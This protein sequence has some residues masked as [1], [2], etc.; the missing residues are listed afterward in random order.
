MNILDEN[1]PEGLGKRP[2]SF[3]IPMGLARGLAV[4]GGL[5]GSIIGKQVPF[6]LNILEKLTGTYTFSS[7]KIQRELGFKPRYNLYNTISDTMRLSFL[8]SSV[9]SVQQLFQESVT[10]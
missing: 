5:A 4:M 6:N 7:L 3:F 9:Y 10:V 1:I 2:R 8:S